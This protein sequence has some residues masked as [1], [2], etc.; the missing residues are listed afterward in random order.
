MLAVLYLLLLARIL[1]WSLKACIIITLVALMSTGLLA[2]FAQ[3]YL[4][5]RNASIQDVFHNFAGILVG[6]AGYTSFRLL[7][8][9]NKPLFSLILLLLTTITFL[10]SETTIK[11]VAYRFLKSGTPIVFSFSD[12]FVTSMISTTGDANASIAGIIDASGE[13]RVRSLRMDFAQQDYSG[14]ILH[15][16]EVEWLDFNTLQISIKNTG[17]VTH[18][19]EIRIHDVHHNNAFEDRFNATLQI[20]PG[21]NKI[22][23]P[24]QQIQTLTS[25][26]RL[27]DMR[28]L[29]E[30]QFF[31]TSRES[32]SLYLTAMNL[33]D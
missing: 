24:V 29:S 32:F 21:E 6:T 23:I 18:T 31:S 5:S 20:N 10:L 12:P 7:A 22:T 4:P 13:K 14:V 28:K 9:N 26:E 8:G 25:T 33:T 19:I 11:L 17:D 3:T 1:P 15:Q 2:E 16:P 30:I 27:M